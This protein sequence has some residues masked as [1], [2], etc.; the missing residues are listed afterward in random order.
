MNRSGVGTG[1]GVGVGIAA[2][3][4]AGFGALL[5]VA[6]VARA[7]VFLSDEQAAHLIFPTVGLKKRELVL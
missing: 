5:P 4:V 3:A 6:I 7:E 2:T 1:I